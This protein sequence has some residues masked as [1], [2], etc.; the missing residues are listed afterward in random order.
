METTEPLF[1]TAAEV[2]ELTGYQRFKKQAVRLAEIGIPFT[3]NAAGRPIVT[4]AIFVGT[5]TAST[6]GKKPRTTWKS[7]AVK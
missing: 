7:N 4:R 6:A 3:L 2:E 5:M 1:L